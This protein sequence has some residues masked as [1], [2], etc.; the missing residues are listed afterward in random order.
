[1]TARGKEGQQFSFFP[2]RGQST[3]RCCSSQS[4]LAGDWQDQEHGSCFPHGGC[5]PQKGAGFEQGGFEDGAALRV[6][7]LVRFPERLPSGFVQLPRLPEATYPEIF[8]EEDFGGV[9][10]AQRVDIHH[11][12]EGIEGQGAGWAQEVPRST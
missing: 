9:E 7:S 4:P 12:F 11:G 1:M 8:L 5:S 3:G 6:Q 2:G 10:G